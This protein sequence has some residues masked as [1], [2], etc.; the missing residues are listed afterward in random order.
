MEA[1]AARLCRY[2]RIL[3]FD[4]EMA[5]GDLYEVAARA[6]REGRILLSRNRRACDLPLVRAFH[7][8]D[9]EPLEQFRKVVR[10]FGLAGHARPFTRCPV[11]NAE[12]ENVEKESVAGAVPPH[13]FATHDRFSRCRGCGRI[14]W[15]G[16][17]VQKMRKVL[18]LDE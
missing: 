6:A 8:E 2:L 5:A 10:H 9:N 15:E 4:A 17:H 13:T 1:N 16:T 12:L 7:L 11:C 3:G 14:Y 18:G